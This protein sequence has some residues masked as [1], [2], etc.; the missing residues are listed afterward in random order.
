MKN[1]KKPY[2][3]AEIGINHNGDMKI[4]KKLI[5]NSKE[6]GFDAVKFQKRDIKLVYS[7]EM[8]ES[9][10][11]SPWGTTFRQQKEGIEFNQNDYE[12]IDKY[13]KSREIDWDWF[14]YDHPH[15]RWV[16]TQLSPILAPQS[17]PYS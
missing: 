16:P 15:P 2:L 6:A 10:R 13:C 9:L 5:D 3:I 4:V 7:K 14:V 17:E 8:L 12:E 1:K 11:E